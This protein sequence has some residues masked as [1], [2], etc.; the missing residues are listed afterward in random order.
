MRCK[1]APCNVDVRPLH[2]LSVHVL[3][4]EEGRSDAACILAACV[5]YSEY[6]TYQPAA[7]CTC[8]RLYGRG[9][10]AMLSGPSSIARTKTKGC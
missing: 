8:L 4:Q 7:L 10:E 5:L 2:F 6:N 9:R 3:L 1:F